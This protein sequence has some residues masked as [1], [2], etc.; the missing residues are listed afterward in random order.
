MIIIEL[1]HY[2]FGII[3]I[4]PSVPT[5]TDGAVIYDDSVRRLTLTVSWEVVV[6]SS[7]QLQSLP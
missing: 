1:I 7:Q 5:I 3:S 4:V 2:L 6:S